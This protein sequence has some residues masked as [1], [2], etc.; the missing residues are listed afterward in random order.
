MIISSVENDFMIISYYKQLYD[1][2]FRLYSY[3]ALNEYH[4]NYNEY[5]MQF[6]DLFLA[7]SDVAV[8][9]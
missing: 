6:Y 4:F 2:I 5:P 7:F 9:E 8:I 3:T 1:N